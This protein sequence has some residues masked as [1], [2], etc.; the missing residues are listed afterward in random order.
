MHEHSSKWIG[1]QDVAASTLE[2][3]M[4]QLGSGA[5]AMATGHNAGVYNIKEHHKMASAGHWNKARVTMDRED[6]AV[7]IANQPRLA[8]SIIRSGRLILNNKF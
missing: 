1:G 4:L 6:V 7:G 5:A 8:S 2:N 3:A